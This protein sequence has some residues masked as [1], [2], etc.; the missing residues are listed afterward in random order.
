MNMDDLPIFV[1]TEIQQDAPQLTGKVYRWHWV[2]EGHYAYL[3]LGDDKFVI[4]KF[5]NV[6]E[7]NKI[8]SFTFEEPDLVPDIKPGDSIQYFD[9]YWGQRAKI[10]FDHTLDWQKTLFEPHDTI[11]IYPDGTKE[12]M[13]GGWDHD[14]CEICWATISKNKNQNFMNSD[15]DDCVCLACFGDYI[16]PKNIDFIKED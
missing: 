10:V 14:H 9:G 15:Q 3:Y 5:C 13:P 2:G 12:D 8:T 4:G 6:E 16:E 7:S 11:A 1:V